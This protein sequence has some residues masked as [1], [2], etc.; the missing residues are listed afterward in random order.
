MRA[1]IIL[2]FLS[3]VLSM[4][5][6]YCCTEAGKVLHYVTTDKKEGKTLKDSIFIKDVADDEERTVVEQR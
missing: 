6:Q 5:A 2:L 3:N 4:S 1:V